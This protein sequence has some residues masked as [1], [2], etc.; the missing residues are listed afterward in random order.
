[1]AARVLLLFAFTGLFATAWS[2]DQPPVSATGLAKRADVL[3]AVVT[4]AQAVDQVDVVPADSKRIEP[5]LEVRPVTNVANLKQ[6]D[7][8][9]CKLPDG[10]T[11]GSYRVVDQQGR[12]GWMSLTLDDLTSQGM[13]SGADSFDMYV[14]RED[15]NV[16]YFIRVDLRE[17]IATVPEGSTTLR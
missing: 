14:S 17:V 3:P 15:R 11:P 6:L 2:F 7:V 10:I 16:W 5:I 12:T 8:S 9:L 13:L 4:H 1:M